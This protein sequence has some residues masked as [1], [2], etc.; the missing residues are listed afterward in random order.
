MTMRPGTV[1]SST[2]SITRGVL[3]GPCAWGEVTR[4]KAISGLSSRCQRFP[5]STYFFF[6]PDHCRLQCLDDL[7]FIAAAATLRQPVPGFLQALFQA[8]KLLASLVGRAGGCVLRPGRFRPGDRG[9]GGIQS[10]VRV[11]L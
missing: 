11:G 9:S 10:I 4:I 1:A 5:G 7:F 6:Q 8:F 3:I 2:L